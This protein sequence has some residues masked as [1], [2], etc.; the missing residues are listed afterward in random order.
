MRKI[1]LF[2]L[3]GTLTDPM[4]G[5]TKSVQHALKAYGIIEEDLTKLCPFIG[6]PLKDSF[7]EFYGFSEKDG[8]EAISVFHEYFTERGI[9]ENKVYEGMEDMLFAL[10]EA[11]Y[12]L[13]VATSKPEIFAIQILEHFKL[14]TY[15]EVV[16]GADMEEIRV[17][18]GDVIKYTLGRL[19]FKDG[20]QVVMVGDRKHDILGA[21]EAG[22]QSIG[23]LYGYG[24]REEF[25]EAGADYM[26]ETV[27]QLKEMLLH[28]YFRG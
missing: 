2:D 1:I 6:P 24:D 28:E 5:I 7:V 18:K 23:V 27:P 10:K 11:G 16:G 20:E 3:D 19:D 21:K 25:E 9:F 8:K 26:V 12:V 15:F 13:A 22:L 17:K 4:E 14:D